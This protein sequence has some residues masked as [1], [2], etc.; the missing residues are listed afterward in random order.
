MRRLVL[1][2]LALL[3]ATARAAFER[4]PLT[5]VA[6]GLGR[7][8]V[9]HGEAS[10]SDDANPAA[11]ESS[12]WGSAA[13]SNPFNVTGLAEQGVRGGLSLGAFAVRGAWQ[14]FGNE[15]HSEDAVSGSARWRRDEVSVGA[16]G[17]YRSRRTTGFAGADDV[18]VDVGALWRVSPITQ[19]GAS[20]RNLGSRTFLPHVEWR[21]GARIEMSERSAFLTDLSLLGA[22]TGVAVG[23]EWTPYPFLSLR[24]GIHN[25][26]W[27][28]AAGFSLGWDALAFDYAVETHASL[29][30]THVV[31]LTVRLP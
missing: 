7:A 28:W 30:A 25:Q 23:G 20:A 14:R 15:I 27:R 16:R 13:Y 21:V 29:D 4:E 22:E 11:V 8:V 1:I 31:G 9:A 18:S 24:G 17:V 12:L 3:S 10:A 19:I 2:S 26:P 6:I 5:P